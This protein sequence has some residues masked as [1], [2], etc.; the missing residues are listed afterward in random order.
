MHEVQFEENL[1]ELSCKALQGKTNTTKESDDKA[2]TAQNGRAARIIK[3][4]YKKHVNPLLMEQNFAK[5]DVGQRACSS[6]SCYRPQV[7]TVSSLLN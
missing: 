4:S 1:L 5:A 3:K 7:S 2:N 6:T